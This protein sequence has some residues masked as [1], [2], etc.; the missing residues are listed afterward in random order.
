MHGRPVRLP[1]PHPRTMPPQN[2]TSLCTCRE[3]HKTLTAAPQT[4]LTCRNIFV[5]RTLCTFR[6]VHNSLPARPRRLTRRF[7]AHVEPPTEQTPAPKPVE[8]SGPAPACTNTNVL[9]LA[10]VRLA[11]NRYAFEPR[12]RRTNAAARTT[13]PTTA[14]MALPASTNWMSLSSTAEKISSAVASLLS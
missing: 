3:M 1:V 14:T 9:R 12:R 11:N 6:K 8:A 4:D 2:S 5:T 10:A 13:Q 7:A